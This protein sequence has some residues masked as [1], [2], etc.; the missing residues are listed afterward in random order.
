MAR[1]FFLG[2]WVPGF[3]RVCF[4]RS[5]G[6]SPASFAITSFA[7]SRSCTLAVWTTLPRGGLPETSD[8]SGRGFRTFQTPSYPFPPRGPVP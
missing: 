7:P 4:F 5:R 1:F 3:L 6:K 2:S 8:R